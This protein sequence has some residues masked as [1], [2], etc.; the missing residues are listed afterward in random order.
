M[1]EAEPGTIILTRVVAGLPAARAG[2]R[3]GDRI[4]RISGHDVGDEAEFARL[5]GTL[6]EPLRLLIERDGRLS[7]VEVHVDT[8]PLRRAA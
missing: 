2:L 1:D 6:P 4:H 7:T 8:E 3:A 5:A